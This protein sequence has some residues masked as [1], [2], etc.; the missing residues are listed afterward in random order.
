M[1]HV[2]MDDINEL[3]QKSQHN[4]ENVKQTLQSMK[5]K[6]EGINNNLIEPMIE[7]AD[8]CEKSGENFPNSPQ[9]LSDVF[10]KKVQN[11]K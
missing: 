2:P 4:W 1:A 3:W 10:N 9:Q 11:F 8:S 7:A 6:S 5:G